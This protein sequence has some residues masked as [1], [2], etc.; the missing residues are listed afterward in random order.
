LAFR[1]STGTTGFV[2]NTFATGGALAAL[3]AADDRMAA[4]PA[5]VCVVFIFVPSEDGESFTP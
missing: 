5:S 3:R 4:T 1:I 2:T